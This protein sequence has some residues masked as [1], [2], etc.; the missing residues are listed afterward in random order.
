MKYG[1]A[2]W[3]VE[4]SLDFLWPFWCTRRRAVSKIELSWDIRELI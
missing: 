1:I 3:E 4:H 2:R